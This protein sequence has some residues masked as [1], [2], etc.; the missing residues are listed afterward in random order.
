MLLV[1]VFLFLLFKL[2]LAEFLGLKN[3]DF[4]TAFFTETLHLLFGNSYLFVLFL[5]DSLAPFII[6]NG[7]VVAFRCLG[8]ERGRATP[9]LEGS[10]G[11]PHRRLLLDPSL[12]FIEYPVH[13]D[14]IPY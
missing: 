6:N 4:E 7:S 10:S 13:F 1:V 14:L 2:L 12:V 3:V 11:G 9:A 8:A 5:V